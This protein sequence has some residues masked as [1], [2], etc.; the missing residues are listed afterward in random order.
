MTNSNEVTLPTQYQQF[1]HKSRY[2]RWLEEEGR[3][4]TWNET[5]DRYIRFMCYNKDGSP[6]ISEQEIVDIR[7]AILHLKI[8]PSMRAMMTAGPALELTNVAGYNCAYTPVDKPIRFAE[9]L[10]ILMC[11]TGIGFSCE[12]SEIDSLPK[13][14]EIL[15]HFNK[16]LV[17]EDSKEGWASAYRELVTH[18]FDGEVCQF[19]LSNL[20]P[21]GARLKTFG[22]R[23]SGPEPL[24]ELFEFTIETFRQAAGRKLKPIEVHDIVC[25]IGE[26]VVVGGVRRSAEISL[27]DL[28]DK[29]MAEAKSGQW[30]VDNPQR[31]LANNSAVYESKP[32]IGEFMD[33]WVS[34]YKS[35]SGER[36]IFSRA[37]ARVLNER[38]GRKND[39]KHGTNPCSEIILRPQQFCNLTEVVV[40]PDDTVE[41]LAN[42]VR[43][44]TIL[45]TLQ[46]RL[47]NFPFL[48]PEWK[49]TT[50]KEALLGVSMT[51]IYDGPVLTNEELTYL[52]SVSEQ[53]NNVYSSRIGIN[54]SAAR[55]C[56]KPSGT[57]SQLVDA[58]SGIHARHS[59]YYIRRVRGDTKDP[60]TQL[61][62]A[63]GVPNE[64]CA[65][66]PDQTVVFSFPIGTHGKITT[67]EDVDAVAHLEK[68][69]Q[70]QKYWC[71]HKPSVTISVREDEWLKVGAWV[72]ENFD[73]MSGVSFLPYA[74]GTYMQAPYE[75]I[76]VFQWQEMKSTFPHINW[77]R[78]AE[79]EKSDNTAGSQTLACTGGVC[80]IVDIGTNE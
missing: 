77:Y 1:I 71:D 76:D 45:G 62:I 65:M 50:E 70:Y 40:R 47:T 34:L 55:T 30:W 2:A 15:G 48:S 73:W 43:L 22:G 69:L 58:A 49:E 56:V 28:S 10:Y 38:V 59:Q 51:G 35:G 52:R 13:V 23:S 68:W 53:T 60:L 21:K 42:K 41:T 37:A 32:S 64:P 54:R 26:V 29:Q 39:V 78:L 20:R 80:E 24:K 44:A 33:E 61:L 46:A 17:I 72:Y 66:K 31:A 67:R 16:T 11:G 12:A 25:K 6:L 19:D 8:L 74:G 18:L 3:R 75:E 4:E 27:S 9:I 36:G 79:F 7:D 5:V 57:A 63:E 14:P